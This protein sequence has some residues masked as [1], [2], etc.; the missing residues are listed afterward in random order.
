MESLRGCMGTF[1][2]SVGGRGQPFL[3]G[4]EYQGSVETVEEVDIADIP[5]F[6]D[7]ASMHIIPDKF[8]NTTI[9]LT[10]L[11]KNN[12]ATTHCVSTLTLDSGNVISEIECQE[13]ESGIL[14]YLITDIAPMLTIDP[15]LRNV[16]EFDAWGSLVDGDVYKVEI[17]SESIGILVPRAQMTT[18]EVAD[19]NGF[20]RTSIA[21]RPLRNINQTLPVGLLVADVP[22]PKE[23]MY[24]I[25][26]S[27]KTADY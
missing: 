8:L 2:I 6:D 9:T 11:S 5:V 15:A 7:N 20:M 13:T 10:N 12:L 19:A 21:F 27:E 17:Q 24:F 4:L 14:N 22:N 26:I 3:L 1:N 18:A 25:T 16:S 23:A